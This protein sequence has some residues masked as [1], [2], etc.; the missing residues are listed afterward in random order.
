LL[1][2]KPSRANKKF[3]SK[4]VYVSS[5]IYHNRDKYD[6]LK[7]IG[8]VIILNLIPHYETYS[9]KLLP[10]KSEVICAEL[11]TIHRLSGEALRVVIAWEIIQ[12]VYLKYETLKA[13]VMQILAKNNNKLFYVD[14][15]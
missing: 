6:A 11:S 12:Q 2:L 15:L 5:Y 14:K 13:Q 3:L 1:Y 9:N 7:D 4:T 10:L 8:S